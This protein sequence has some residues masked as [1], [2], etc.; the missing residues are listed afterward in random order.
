MSEMKQQA[1]SERSVIKNDKAQR[2]KERTKDDLPVWTPRVVAR[3]RVHSVELQLVLLPSAQRS[4]T[5]S[6]EASCHATQLVS[7]LT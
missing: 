4:T 1:V 2:A 5:E 7:L 3:L 6:V